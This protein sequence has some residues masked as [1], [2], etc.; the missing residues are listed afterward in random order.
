MELRKNQIDTLL[1]PG[2][3]I[4]RNPLNGRNFEY[5]S[6]DP[7]VACT[8]AAAQLKGMGKYGVTGTIKHF[9]G[10]NQ[11]FKRHDANGVVSERALREI[12]LKGFEIAVKEGHAYSI[13]S[14]YGPINGIWTAGS[15]DLLTTILRKDWGYQGVV[16]TDWWAKMN[17]EGEEGSQSNTIPMVR[18]QNDVYMVVSDSASNSANDN[19]MEGLADGRLTRGQL[20]RNA[21]NICHFL[22]RSPVM[23][24]FCDREFDVCEEINNPAKDA[25][26][27]NLIAS[28]KVEKEAKL[29]LT[30]LSTQKGVRAGYLLDVSKAGSYQMIFKMHSGENPFAQLPVS[31]F[32]NGVLQQTTTFNGTDNKIIERAVTISFPES[33]ENQLTLFFGESGV[34][35]DEILLVQE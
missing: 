17:E 24:R 12:Y 14:T 23:N 7:C 15:Y 6:E 4:H 30:K 32:V 5:F 33:G 21:K 25:M 18:A 19:T 34:R 31:I 11:E 26:A 13:M 22:M 3:N 16:M 10:N 35:M 28:Q 27:G 2:M 8:M 20:V 29:D 9:A 1:G